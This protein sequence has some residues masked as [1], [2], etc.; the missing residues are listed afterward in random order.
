MLGITL[1][2]PLLNPPQS[3]ILGIGAKHTHLTLDD[4]RL[5]AIPLILVTVV[6]DHR[7]VDG[8]AS[9][10]FLMRVKELMEKPTLALG[11]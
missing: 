9:G 5:K 1:S 11:Y 2:I 7:V 4:G 3:A 6:A 10:A 8:A